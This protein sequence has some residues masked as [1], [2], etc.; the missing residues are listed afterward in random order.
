MCLLIMQTNI[1]L[2]HYAASCSIIFF[3]L[4]Y[5]SWP[6][7]VDFKNKDW[8]VEPNKKYHRDCRTKNLRWWDSKTKK[9]RPRGSETIKPPHRDPSRDLKTFFWRAFSCRLQFL[10]SLT[11]IASPQCFR[12]FYFTNTSVFILDLSHV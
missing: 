12:Q 11:K 1:F 7:F 5:F 3:N 9:P 8:A 4:W 2:V 10:F 6:F